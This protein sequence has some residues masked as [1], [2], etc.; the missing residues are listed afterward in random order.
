MRRQ[1]IISA[2]LL[3]TIMAIAFAQQSGSIGELRGV[4]DGTGHLL[5]STDTSDSVTAAQ[6]GL[7]TVDAVVTNTPTVIV[8]NIGPTSGSAYAT[9]S[10]YHVTTASTNAINCKASAANFYGVRAVNASGTIAY[11]RLYNLAV[12]P[13]C[14]SATG[15]IESVPIPAAAGGFPTVAL[16]IIPTQYGTGIGFCVTGGGTSTDNTNAVAGTYIKIK[17]K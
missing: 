6:G 5:V 4:V 17:Y 8:D 1:V 15:F 3:L 2:L 9:D 7:W 16:E 10:C 11:L 12:A 13:T 14:S